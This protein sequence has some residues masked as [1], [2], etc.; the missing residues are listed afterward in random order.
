LGAIIRVIAVVEAH[1]RPTWLSKRPH[2][3]YSTLTEK[4]LNRLDYTKRQDGK[5]VAKITHSLDKQQEIL[6]CHLAD[7]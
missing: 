2:I 5:V 6:L 3:F 4:Q 7:A 1:K